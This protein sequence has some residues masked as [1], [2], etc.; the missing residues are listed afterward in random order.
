MK[1]KDPEIGRLL[2]IVGMRPTSSS[3]SLKEPFLCGESAMV[4]G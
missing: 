2:W 4:M 3:K 1:V